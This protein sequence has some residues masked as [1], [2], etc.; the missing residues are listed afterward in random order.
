MPT[1]NNCAP[2]FTPLGVGNTQQLFVNMS[3]TLPKD[4]F[5]RELTQNGIDAITALGPNKHGRVFWHSQ[6]I[7]RVKKL[8]VSDTGIGMTA[9]FLA[10][11]MNVLAAHSTSGRNFG[12]GAKISL[13]AVSPFGVLYYTLRDGQAV[14]MRIG[15]N[16]SGQW[17]AGAPVPVPQRDWVS[18][19]HPAV[20]K[21]GHGTTVV[22]LGAS[23]ADSTATS[24]VPK[25]ASSPDSGKAG[26]G[27]HRYLNGRYVQVPKNVKIFATRP[28]WSSEHKR[29]VESVREIYGLRH[30]WNQYWNPAKG[31]HK[32]K[33]TVTVA[34]QPVTC[35]WY[36]FPE[37]MRVPSFVKIGGW[38]RVAVDGECYIAKNDLSAANVFASQKRVEFLFDFSSLPAG[39][40]DVNQERTAVTVNRQ[41]VRVD[42]LLKDVGT[43][44]PAPIV[45]MLTQANTSG[46]QMRSA[47]AKVARH[48]D[49]LATASSPCVVVRRSQ[50]TLTGAPVSHVSTGAKLVRRTPATTSAAGGGSSSG[51]GAAV[52][53][54]PRAR[55]VG[56]PAADGTTPLAAVTPSLTVPSV[57]WDD[58][59]PEVCSGV[60][61][62]YFP[63]IDQLTC[64]AD[65]P[66]YNQFLRYWLDQE[67]KQAHRLVAARRVFVQDAVR[68]VIATKLC[69]T[70]VMVTAG[71]GDPATLLSPQ[72][73]TAVASD[74]GLNDQ[75]RALLKPCR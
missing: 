45:A 57:Q 65:S 62:E 22:L 20:I 18:V 40:V 39:M 30:Y 74:M 68:E 38:A 21:A 3:A 33:V 70:V 59:A 2:V 4:Q 25:S 26:W 10:T 7:G 58:H 63:A 44:L 37:D 34:G 12:V 31:S 24:L 54:S 29:L 42:D 19:F 52:S 55:S 72:A 71:G 16:Q 11:R 53:A 47:Q 6:K 35:Y 8:A 13:A 67:K 1:N 15:M 17:G 75:I 56:Q 36:L 32:G 69:L 51:S 14:S 23:Q 9:E 41:P 43:Q 5:I 64:Y 46:R 28:Q 61:A 27:I 49:F 73:L 60:V 66:I 48:A 50:A